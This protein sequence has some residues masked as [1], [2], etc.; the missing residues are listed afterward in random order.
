MTDSTETQTTTEATMPE[1][2]A[3]FRTL[4]YKGETPKVEESGDPVDTPAI[5]ETTTKTETQTEDTPDETKVEEK[6]KKQT[7]QERIDEITAKRREAERVADE[8]ARENAA[9]LERIKQ[10]EALATPAEPKA[11]VTTKTETAAPD[12]TAVDENGE[13]VYPLGEFDPKYIADL[14]RYEFK[15]LMEEK[16]KEEEVLQVKTKEEQAREE[17]VTNW[18]QKL[19]EARDTKYPDFEEKAAQIQIE[20]ADIDPQYGDFLAT[21]IMGLDNGDDVLYYLGENIDEAKAIANSGG[22]AAVV[23]LGRLSARL[24]KSPVTTEKPKVKTSKAPEPPPILNKGTST[25]DTIRADT[26]SLSEFKR[27][28]WPNSKRN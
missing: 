6:P 22:I 17:L 27:L 16:T 9:L 14:T 21:T 15:R 24:E 23:A 8:K 1:S 3:D 18:N 13:D 4:L 26:A 28:L 19:I 10:L 20:F 25:S 12:P 2:L 7:L 11:P 5:E